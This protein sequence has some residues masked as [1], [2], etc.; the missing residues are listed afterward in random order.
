MTEQARILVAE[1]DEISQA[2]VQ[3]M[4]GTLG[5]LELTIVSNG[6]EALIECMARK[7]DLL[8]VD[9]KM[10]LI[11]GDRLIRQL[12]T[13]GN[14]NAETPI[15]LFSAS[16]AAELKEMGISNMADMVLSKP[17]RGGEFLGAVRTLVGARAGIRS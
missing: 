13:S 4:L 9:R 1:D 14:P 8:I 6:R 16:T 11:T 15:I 7:F 2:I 10:P 17:I 5:P 3:Q 12:R